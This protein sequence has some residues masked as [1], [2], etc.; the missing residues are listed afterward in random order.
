MPAHGLRVSGSRRSPPPHETGLA[1]AARALGFEHHAVTTLRDKR[2]CQSLEYPKSVGAYHS[3]FLHV[4]DYGHIQHHRITQMG[5][6]R[7][8]LWTSTGRRR[9]PAPDDKLRSAAIWQSAHRPCSSRLDAP[10]ALACKISPV[11]SDC[12]GKVRHQRVVTATDAAWY[13]AA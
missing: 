2:M 4:C 13:R 8:S 7:H 1:A 12:G 11:E 5:Y 3:R 9:Q 6:I 10:Q